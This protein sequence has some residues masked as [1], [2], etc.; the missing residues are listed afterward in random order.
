MKNLNELSTTLAEIESSTNLNLQGIIRQTQYM[1]GVSENIKFINR[2][3]REIIKRNID[4]FNNFK[5]YYRVLDDN[6]QRLMINK[7]LL[8]N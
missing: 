8:K 5:D 4:I 6:T 1:M 7:Y 3:K 2:K